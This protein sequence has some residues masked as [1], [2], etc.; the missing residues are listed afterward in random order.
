MVN[1][2]IYSDCFSFPVLAKV[3]SD[4]VTHHLSLDRAGNSEQVLF[5]KGLGCSASKEGIN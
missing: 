3:Y 2:S 4:H 1:V 5:K